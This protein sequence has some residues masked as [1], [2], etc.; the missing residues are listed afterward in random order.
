MKIAISVELGPGIRLAAPQQIKKF[1]S[2]DPLAAPNHLVF[3]H[4]DVSRGSAKRGGSKTQGKPRQ[5][6]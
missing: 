6:S 3:H 1:L 5:L 4:G 2:G